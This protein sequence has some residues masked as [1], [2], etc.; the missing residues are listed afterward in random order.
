MY[1]NETIRRHFAQCPKGRK[2]IKSYW[3][4]STKTNYISEITEYKA[5]LVARGVL[6]ELGY[7]VNSLVIYEDI[8]LC[9]AIAKYSQGI[10]SLEY[11][12]S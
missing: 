11:I 12:P 6:T 3:I 8:Q 1:K 5:T 2:L 4:F 7:N 9:I 10:I